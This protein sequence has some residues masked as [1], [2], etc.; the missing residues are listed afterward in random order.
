MKWISVKDKPIPKDVHIFIL[1]EHGDIGNVY[2]NDFFKQFLLEMC[3]DFT[4]GV[5]VIITHWMPLPK[6]PKK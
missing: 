1:T 2:W 4:I 6:P 3:G 5:V